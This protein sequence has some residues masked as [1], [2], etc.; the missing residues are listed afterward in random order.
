LFLLLTFPPFTF[1]N[2]QDPQCWN[3]F[4]YCVQWQQWD[5]VVHCW[6]QHRCHQQRYSLTDCCCH[7][8][9]HLCYRLPQWP[10]SHH[11]RHHHHHRRHCCCCCC[12][13]CCYCYCCYCYCWQKRQSLDF[14]SVWESCWLFW[15]F[16]ELLMIEKESEY[17]VGVWWKMESTNTITW[18]TKRS[19]LLSNLFDKKNSNYNMSKKKTY[20]ISEEDFEK[21]KQ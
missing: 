3:R 14:D 19:Q 15:V 21:T 13:C 9:H 1:G 16:R 6:C 5:P 12:C 11:C 17:E 8:C 4:H 10:N 7:R 20:I 18:K 2:C